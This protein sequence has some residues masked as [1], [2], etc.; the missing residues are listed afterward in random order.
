MNTLYELALCSWP[1]LLFR[2]GLQ[3]TAQILGERQASEM[4][5]H[6]SLPTANRT[7]ARYRLRFVGIPVFGRTDSLD[8]FEER[9]NFILYN[10]P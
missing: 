4:T 10:I 6:A 9:W 7:D 2:R 1:L 5:I 3:K 8:L